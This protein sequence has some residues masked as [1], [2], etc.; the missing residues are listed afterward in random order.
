MELKADPE[1]LQQMI[2]SPYN[3]EDTRW[4]AYQNQAMDSSSLGHLQFLAVGPKNT[5][6]E[7]PKQCPDTRYVGWKYRFTGWVDLETGE[8]SN[9]PPIREM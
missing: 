7:P 2:D 1:A 6:K 8:V 5:F 3:H 4:A 9:A